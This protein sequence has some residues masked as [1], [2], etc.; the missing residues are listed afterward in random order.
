ML[1][2]PEQPLTH[3]DQPDRASALV[4]SLLDTR[5]IGKVKAHGIRPALDS[6]AIVLKAAF[7]KTPE[8]QD[9]LEGDGM[10][11]VRNRRP[12]SGVI[13]NAISNHSWGTAIDLK[14]AG[15]QPPGATGSAIPN[16]IALL[17]P[18]FNAAGWFSG[19][20]FHDDMHFEVADQTIRDWASKGLFKTTPGVAPVQ[21]ASAGAMIAAPA[22]AAVAAAAPAAH[23]HEIAEAAKYKAAVEAAARSCSLDPLLIYA[24]GSR[25]SDWGLTLRPPGPS[26]TGDFAPRNP[27]KWGFAMPPDGLGWGRGLLQ[28]DYQQAFGQTGNW[29]D[30]AANIL[31]GA[32][33]LANDINFFA[34]KAFP[35]VDPKRAGIAAYNCGPGGVEKAIRKGL[36]VDAFTT[37]KDYSADVLRR[38]NWF[39]S[40]IS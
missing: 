36:D 22:P 30:P 2:R 37:G 8:L 21:P 32:Q 27:A 10:L 4:K 5:I 19:I 13:S 28:V 9:V 34:H 18:H 15:F 20:S 3:D 24:I 25:E 7:A 33:E 39:A 1:G 11:V 31:H 6:L 29:R 38:M 12:T 23:A 14:L 16:F 35:G 40:L 17:V 26:G